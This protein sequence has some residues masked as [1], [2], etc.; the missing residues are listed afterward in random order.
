[1]KGSIPKK[2][3]FDVQTVQITIPPRQQWTH[4]GKSTRAKY[5]VVTSAL[6]SKLIQ[7]QICANIYMASMGN[8]GIHP[9]DKDFPGCQRCS[10]IGKNVLF[11]KTSK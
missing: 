5:L 1:M 11:A 2:A 10:D 8:C 6:S 4:R 7:H 9:A 3:Y